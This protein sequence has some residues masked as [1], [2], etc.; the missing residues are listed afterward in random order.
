MPRVSH[1]CIVVKRNFLVARHASIGLTP[2]LLPNCDELL[3]LKGSMKQ[4]ERTQ[5]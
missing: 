4:W 1:L 3:S 5:F 2:E